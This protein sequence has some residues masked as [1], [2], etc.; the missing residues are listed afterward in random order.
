M[1]TISD[2]SKALYLVI[3][4]I[5]I[6]A[7][8]AFWLDSIGAIDITTITKKFKDEPKSVVNATDDEPSLIEREEFEKEKD[9][10]L[11]RVEELDKR[12]SILF[13]REKELEAENEKILEKIKGLDLE[14]KKFS[15][16][17]NEYAGYEKNVKVL[18]KKIGNMPPKDSVNIMIKWED[19]LIIAVLR[20]MDRA[21]TEAGKSSITSYL[22]T[23]MPKEKA[24]R[25]MYLMTQL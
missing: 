2:K 17:K 22:L 8:G 25:I 5:F 21:A 11:V 10:L 6:S 12:E 9:K 3:L 1:N 14:K 19:S 18:A 24:S 4:I 15:D 23:L 7:F 20:E 16:E 13:E